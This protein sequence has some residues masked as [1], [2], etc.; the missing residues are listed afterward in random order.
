MTGGTI[1]RASRPI[2]SRAA[3]AALALLGVA[4]C[5]GPGALPPG[6]AT[7]VDVV[8]G[9]T[10][11]LDFG[12]QTEIVRLLG[13]DTPE[14]VH[15]DK[16]VECFGPEASTRTSELLSAGTPVTVERD[17]EARDRFDRLLAH[18]RIT[19]SDTHVNLALVQEGM[20]DT[21][22]IE[23]NQ[24]YAPDFRAAAAQARTL[25]LGLWSACP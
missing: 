18:I 23:P 3:T 9:D 21:L 13:V 8:D 4:A 11:V 24:A 12:D 1:V 20:A 7:V 2:I 25:G 10:V 22:I 16:P 5:S 19:E 17:T 14:T 6:Q 15:P